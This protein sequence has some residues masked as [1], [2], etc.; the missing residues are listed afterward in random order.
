MDIGA[1]TT[2]ELYERYNSI[3]EQRR[4]LEA[5]KLL[6]HTE[7]TRREAFAPAKPPSGR[8][9]HIDLTLRSPEVLPGQ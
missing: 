1:A 9:Q 5:E 7:I 8:S 3:R 2:P 6:I 4:A